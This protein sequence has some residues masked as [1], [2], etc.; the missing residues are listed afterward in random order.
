MLS[1]RLVEARQM[2][3]RKR[4]ENRSV[5]M[6]WLCSKD[7]YSE[8]RQG[9]PANREEFVNNLIDFRHSVRITK[10]L[11]AE[12]NKDHSFCLD[13]EEIKG[14]KNQINL[15]ECRNGK[16]TRV[17]AFR[18]SEDLTLEKLS[19]DE[20]KKTRIYQRAFKYFTRKG[21][22]EDAK[23]VYHDYLNDP[24]IRVG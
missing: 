21:V 10:R 8:D 9:S 11:L 7:F 20:L 19:F 3:S 13:F 24:E 12:E 16:L 4:E 14:G 18:D 5:F 1:D 17:Y 22:P 2:S 23:L 6:S 15:V